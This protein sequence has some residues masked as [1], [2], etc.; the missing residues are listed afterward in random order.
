MMKELQVAKQGGDLVIMSTQGELK[1]AILDEVLS[2]DMV[3]RALYSK[4]GTVHKAIVHLNGWQ[5][6]CARTTHILTNIHVVV[7]NMQAWTMKYKGALLH[8]PKMMRADAVEL[9]A[10]IW[11]QIHNYE[12]LPQL[13][14]STQASHARVFK[15]MDV[16]VHTHAIPSLGNLTHE[17]TK[18]QV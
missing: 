15:S 2:L 6:R 18:K 16:V 4:F 5:Q 17:K 10:R 9:Q 12:D 1:K 3:M 11:S 8:L 13:I 14:T 7:D